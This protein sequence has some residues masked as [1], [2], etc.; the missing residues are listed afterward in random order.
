MSHQS[1]FKIVGYTAEPKIEEIVLLGKAKGI[2]TMMDLGSGLF[3][4]LK[5]KG[6]G[7]EQTVED[8]LKKKIDIVSFSGDKL[9]GGPQAGII[10]SNRKE[11]IIMMRNNPLLRAL[12]IDKFTV[13][14]LE[15]IL[16]IYLY[17][18][19]PI[20]ELPHL[21]MAFL[22]EKDMKNKAQTIKR[23]IIKNCGKKI[24]VGITKG[25]SQMGGGS[26]PG[27]MIPTYLV[28]I[29][30]KKFSADKLLSLLRENTPPI[31][32]RKEKDEIIIDP[33][34]VFTEEFPEIEKALKR[35]CDKF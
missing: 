32:A 34:T 21:H 11:F 27:E 16:R 4:D 8:I 24:E 20:E 35:I 1:N 12:R 14:A 9:L 18:G 31:I 5:S 13:S 6:L 33:R 10:L 30:H 25:F 15:A 22:T 26:M 28:T 29:T 2:I 17:S 19:N 23:G 3:V 7:E